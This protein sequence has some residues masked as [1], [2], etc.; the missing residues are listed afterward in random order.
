MVRVVI[1][2]LIILFALNSAVCAF[3]DSEALELGSEGGEQQFMSLGGLL[4]G[5][6]PVGTLGSEERALEMLEQAYTNGM[7]QGDLTKICWKYWDC[8]II[9]TYGNSGRNILGQV[10]TAFN[11]GSSESLNMEFPQETE[12]ELQQALSE[13]A[14]RAFAAASNPQRGFAKCNALD[15]KWKCVQMEVCIETDGHWPTGFFVNPTGVT[16][17]GTERRDPPA[18]NK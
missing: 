3:A 11:R 18:D 13:N 14:D 8:E 16:S 17:T 7:Y 9:L 4:E 6:F 5:G 1:R 10:K 2:S 12:A 15:L